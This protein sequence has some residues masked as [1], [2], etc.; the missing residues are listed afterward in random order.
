[1]ESE[2]WIIIQ[3][4]CATIKLMFCWGFLKLDHYLI[5]SDYTKNLSKLICRQVPYCLDLSMILFYNNN[6]SQHYVK[7][8]MTPARSHNDCSWSTVELGGGHHFR[9]HR[10]WY[11]TSP[12][13]GDL[14]LCAEPGGRLEGHKG[15]W[16]CRLEI[17]VSKSICFVM[18]LFF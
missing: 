6:A 11:R 9:W 2:D 18:F 14:L 5:R 17:I 12:L 1:M 15:E 8:R 7:L 4:L 13:W 3:S 10:G 16:M